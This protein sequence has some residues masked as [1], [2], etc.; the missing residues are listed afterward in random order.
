VNLLPHIAPLEDRVARYERIVAMR[1]KDPPMSYEDIAEALGPDPVT[2]EVLT[3]E[4]IRQ[5]I[6]RPPK[7]PGRPP[8][9]DRATV[10]RRKLAFWEQRRARLAAA[11][12][13]TA[14]P[15]ERIRFL[16]RELAR[17]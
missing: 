7:R 13:S 6:D 16:S 14:Q 15:D 2:G 8:S 10:L 5:I 3:R 4:R 11:G 12:R 17:L 9:A 1:S